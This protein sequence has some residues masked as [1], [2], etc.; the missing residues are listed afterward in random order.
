ME[1]INNWQNITKYA[2][3]G[4]MQ[5]QVDAFLKKHPFYRWTGH[6][7]EER[8]K[9]VLRE[10]PIREI[11]R[12]SDH[13][14][15]LDRKRVINIECKL[16]N[17]EEVIHQAADHLE[18][19]DYSVICLPPDAKYVPN[20]HKMEILKK[21]LGLFYWFKDLGIFEFILPKFNR[22]KNPDLRKKIIERILHSKTI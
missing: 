1:I 11:G 21:G 15:L 18:W 2:S 19:C 22:N 12:V 5:M 7:R 10:F 17:T 3:E 4:D 6:G 16:H 13:I 8:K 14:L 20:Y 9:I